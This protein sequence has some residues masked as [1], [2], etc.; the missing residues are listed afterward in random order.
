MTSWTARTKSASGRVVQAELQG[1]LANLS[2]RRADPFFINEK[3]HG[4][5]GGGRQVPT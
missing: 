1:K 5:Y 2:P 4:I 3:V